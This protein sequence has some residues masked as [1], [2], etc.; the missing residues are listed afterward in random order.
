MKT[1][2]EIYVDEDEIIETI[3]GDNEKQIIKYVKEKYKKHWV[4]I[5]RINEYDVPKMMLGKKPIGK[6][7]IFDNGVD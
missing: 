1:Y 2:Y 7:L 6:T 3:D 5:Y 4:T